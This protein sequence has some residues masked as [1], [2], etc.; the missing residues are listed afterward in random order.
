ME[1]EVKRTF[2]LLTRLKVNHP[3]KPDILAIK[4]HGDWIKISVKQY[5]DN[6]HYIAY[7]LL[8]LGY[9]NEDKAITICNNRPE[10]NFIDMGLNLAKMVHVPVYTTLSNDD[11]IHIFNHSDA[12]IIFVGNESIYK[13]VAQIIEK[14]EVKPMVIMMDDSS[15]IESISS[16]YKLGKE[17]E[18][19]YKTIVDKI[20]KETS[21]NDLA[22]II[23]TSGTAGC[24]KGVML[25]HWNLM[26][27][28]IAHAVKQTVT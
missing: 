20:K 22:T 3:D 23:Y 21:P 4:K 25:S 24:P 13:K 17:K 7:A 11:Y 10:W 19:E 28:A 18:D 5:I 26:F 27:N 15:T 2:D 16:L 9:G 14:L 12:K 8:S 6:S 1:I